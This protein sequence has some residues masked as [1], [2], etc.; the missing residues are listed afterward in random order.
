MSEVTKNPPL[1]GYYAALVGSVAGWS[2][3]VLHL[4]FLVPALAMVLGTYFLAMRFGNSSLLAAMAAL[5]TPGV[6][7]SASSV[8]CDTMD[9]GGILGVGSADMAGWHDDT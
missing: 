1:A 3:R 8:M 2:E 7:V 5:C 4:A 6:V 9:D